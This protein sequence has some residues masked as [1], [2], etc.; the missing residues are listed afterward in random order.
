[1][2]L[3]MIV[4]R[5]VNRRSLY[6]AYCDL[7]KESNQLVRSGTEIPKEWYILDCISWLIH[8]TGRCKAFYYKKKAEKTKMHQTAMSMS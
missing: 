6:N 4:T 2:G 5:L 1:M 7:S 3:C 8:V